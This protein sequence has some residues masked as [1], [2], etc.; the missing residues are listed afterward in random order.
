MQKFAR[1]AE[2]STKIAAGTFCVYPVHSRLDYCN[3]LFADLP[4]ARLQ[5]VPRDAA[6]LFLH[7]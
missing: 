4:Y 3:S 1:T 6:K 5:C 7:F 2:I